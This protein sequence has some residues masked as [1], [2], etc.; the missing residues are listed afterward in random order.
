MRGTMWRF[1][2]SCCDRRTTHTTA[3]RG[4]PDYPLSRPAPPPNLIPPYSARTPHTCSVSPSS[5]PLLPHRRPAP[6]REGRL[7]ALRLRHAYLF[8]ADDVP[9]SADISYDD[10]LILCSKRTPGL[11]GDLPAVPSRSSTRPGP[12]DWGCSRCRRAP[13]ARTRA[14]VSALTRTPARHRLMLI[15]NKL[16]DWAMFDLPASDPG[17]QLFE[18]ARQAFTEAVVAQG[19][20]NGDAK[21]RADSRLRRTVRPDARL[22]LAMEAGELLTMARRSAVAK[23]MS[24]ELAAAAARNLRAPPT[25]RRITRSRRAATRCWDRWA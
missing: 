19:P 24:G 2:S 11:G 12:R 21:G 6:P 9:I 23:R 25:R 13:A 16:E 4:H 5:N 7:R 1:T 18:Q 14:A 3:R 22:R 20:G 15:L 10:G 17:M 8:A